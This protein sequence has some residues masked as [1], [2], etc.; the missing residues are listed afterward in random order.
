MRGLAIA[1]SVILSTSVLAAATANER[2][3]D[4]ASDF[5]E[6][7]RTPDRAIPQD[8][9]AKAQCVV[10]IPGL[11]KAGFIVGAEY[12]RGFVECRRLSGTGWG[13][14]AAIKLEG[15]SVGFQLGATDTDLVML[16]MN[17]D[18]MNKL[19]RDKFTVGADASAAAGPVGRTAAAETDAE[20]HAEM[21]TWSRSKG[22]FAGISLNGATIRP[23]HD[24]NE[25][26]YGRKD[27]GTH[28]VLQ[29]GMRPPAE[30]RPLIHELDR[31]SMTSNNADRAK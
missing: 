20:M 7:M 19:M 9:L 24:W 25:Q 31:Y 1:A 26:L 12:G 22:L 23:A 18:G 15:G 11:K 8:L 29:G 2:L 14:P 30:A 16:V 6:I 17:R 4:A 5:S 21:L 28:A 27:L 13:A 3:A 10:I